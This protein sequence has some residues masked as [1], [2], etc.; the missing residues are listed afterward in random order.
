MVESNQPT[1]I[2][3]RKRAL[4]AAKIAINK[5]DTTTHDIN[6]SSEPAPSRTYSIALKSGSNG[7][8]AWNTIGQQK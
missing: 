5:T 8:Q 6:H 2:A 1:I 3:I 4:R 7:S